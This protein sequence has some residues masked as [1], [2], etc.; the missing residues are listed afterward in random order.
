M[1]HVK[2]GAILDGGVAFD[3]TACAPYHVKFASNGK[4][5]AP[6]ILHCIMSCQKLIL[7]I[8]LCALVVLGIDRKDLNNNNSLK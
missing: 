8:N 1:Q 6:E 2:D 3:T 5:N 7:S 4:C